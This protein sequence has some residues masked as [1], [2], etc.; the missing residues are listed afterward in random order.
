[1]S[2][3]GTS[4]SGAK[5]PVNGNTLFEIGSI[6]KIFTALL[7]QDIVNRGEVKQ[8]DKDRKRWLP[9]W[10]QVSSLEFGCTSLRLLT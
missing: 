6:A 1:M 5:N 9:Y 10:L 4:R 8:E 2:A 7:L 3:Y